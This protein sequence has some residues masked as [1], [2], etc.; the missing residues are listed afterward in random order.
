MLAEDVIMR[1]VDVEFKFKDSIVN[2]KFE[3]FKAVVAEEEIS[4]VSAC[5]GNLS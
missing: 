3:A 4:G 1:A 5:S 2:E